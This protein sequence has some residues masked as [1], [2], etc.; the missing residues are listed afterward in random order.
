MFSGTTQDFTE[1]LGARWCGLMHDSP[2][3]PIHGQYE[4]RTCGRRY[5]VQWA[6]GGTSLMRQ[7]PSPSVKFVE[8]PLVVILA[9]LLPANIHGAD[10]PIVTSN[11]GAEMVFARYIACQ[12]QTPP[13]N[14]GA[15][16]IDTSLLAPGLQAGPTQVVG[17]R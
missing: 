13:W 3:W 7:T 1:Q 10:A 5:P 15:I 4:C 16:E 12:T 2:M 9:M 17:P 11:N 8:L 14:V 6:G